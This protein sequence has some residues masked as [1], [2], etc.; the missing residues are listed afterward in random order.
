MKDLILITAYCPDDNRLNKL[1][2]LV[3]G[4]S[5]YKDKIDIMIVSHTSIPVDIQKNVNLYLFDDKNELLTDWDLITQPWFSPNGNSRSIQSGL[6]TN[7]N[8]QLAIWRMFILGFSLAKN[9]GYKKVHQIEYDCEI[10]SIDEIQKNSD[11]LNTY[12]CVYYLDKQDE[13][14]TKMLRKYNKITQGI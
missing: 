5:E 1:R 9:I 2:N 12:N 10:Q 4:L 6:L 13:H 3:R 14:S 11:L 8:T 7:R